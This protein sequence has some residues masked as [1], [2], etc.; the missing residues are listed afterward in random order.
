MRG[1]IEI[2]LRKPVMSFMIV[3]ALCLLGGVSITRLPVGL[4]PNLASP[5]ITIITRYPGVAS[6]KIEELLTI[7]IERTVSDIA[8]I[9]K[10]I[11]TSSEGE[12][13]INLIFEHD[14]DIKIKILEASERIHIIRDGFPREVEE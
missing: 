14:A 6:E 3:I 7:P 8:G 12:S 9:E 13:R 11:S 2:F 4:L 10:I 1:V 5:G